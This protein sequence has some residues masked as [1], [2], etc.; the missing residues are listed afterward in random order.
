MT[1][2]PRSIC[3]LAR[4]AFAMAVFAP[5]AMPACS[6][7]SSGL[8]IGDGGG[9]NIDGERSTTVDALGGAGGSVARLDAGTPGTGGAVMAGDAA[10]PSGIDS[11]PAGNGGHSGSDGA[12]FGGAGGTAV[13]DAGGR[14][15]DV[16]LD[17]PAS[18][19]A[20][21]ADSA[22]DGSASHDLAVDPPRGR[23]DSQAVDESAGCGDLGEPCCAQRT[24]NAAGLACTSSTGGG[25]GTCAV[26]GGAGQACCEGDVCT[27]PGTTCSGGGRSGGT[28]R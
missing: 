24:C 21:S 4:S 15:A 7:D 12:M 14:T 10:V 6:S 22:A 20:E 26:C 18:D 23:T 25:Q 16:P 27:A 5:L 28:C 19:A 17:V 8:R 2:R 1:I 3:L 11:H 13:L 9:I